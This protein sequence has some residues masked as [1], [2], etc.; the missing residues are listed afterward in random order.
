MAQVREE[1]SQ[2]DRRTGLGTV[3]EFG[4]HECSRELS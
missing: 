1:N 2:S 4:I 3:S